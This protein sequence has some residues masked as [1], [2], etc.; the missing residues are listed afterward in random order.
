MVVKNK[1]F[2]FFICLRSYY[3]DV[4]DIEMI[5][6]GN[7]MLLTDIVIRFVFLQ[8]IEQVIFTH[9]HTHVL[10]HICLRIYSY[11]STCLCLFLCRRIYIQA[12]TCVYMI[13]I[14]ACIKIDIYFSVWQTVRIYVI[15]C[16]IAL[17]IYVF[18]QVI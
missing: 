17:F 10:T 15:I 2:V 4:H 3:F 8:R 6:K 9:V 11:I 12:Y 5:C 7:S 18:L 1:L 13:Y 14:C 16:L